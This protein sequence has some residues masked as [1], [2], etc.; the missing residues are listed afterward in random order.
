MAIPVYLLLGYL[1][2]ITIFGKGPT[3]LIY[4]PF[5]LGEIVLAAGLFWIIDRRGLL[6][7]LLPDQSPLTVL[8][9]LFCVIGLAWTAFGVREYGLD[10]VRDGAIWYYALFYF[11]GMELAREDALAV[12]SWRVLSFCWILAL[13]WTTTDLLGPMVFG[14]K[15][16]DLSP[17][18]PWRGERLLSNSTYESIQHMALAS[19]IVL[20]PGLRRHRFRRWLPLLAPLSIVALISAF[21]I[22][23]GRGVKLGLLLALGLAALLAIAPRGR[24]PMSKRIGQGLI[25]LALLGGTALLLMPDAALRTLR[26]DRSNLAARDSTASFRLIWWQRLADEVHRRN[27]WFGLGFGQSLNVYNPFLRGNERTTWPAR[28]PHNFN[29]TVFS[30]MGYVGLAVWT[31]ILV[32]GIGGLFRRLWNGGWRGRRYETERRDQLVFWLILLVATWGNAS[33]GVLMEGP[34]LGIWFWFA[35]GFARALS[36]PQERVRRWQAAG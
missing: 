23:P 12:R 7:F 18:L 6:R 24:N 25:G 35:L 22:L 20:N 36:Q 8:I 34:V 17:V 16:S 10:A 1:G 3:Y 2:L 4:P 31:G 30:R 28:S 26:L 19:V 15:I 5:F 33:F 29:V 9:L 32:I 13:A 11:I 27:P 21:S 14:A